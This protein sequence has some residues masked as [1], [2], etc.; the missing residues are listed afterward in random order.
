MRPTQP[1]WNRSSAFS[2][3]PAEPLDHGEHQ[4]QI[5]LDQ[6]PAG[7]LV[8]GLGAGGSSSMV[9]SFF[10]HLQLC[11]VDPGDLHLALHAL[12]PLKPGN[13]MTSSMAG[14]LFSYT[15]SF[16]RFLPVCAKRCWDSPSHCIGSGQGVSAVQCRRSGIS[17]ARRSSTSATDADWD[18]CRT[19]TCRVPEGQVAAII[20]YGP[21]RFFGLF[22][23][24][25]EFYI[26]WECIQRIGDDI[27]LIDKPFQRRDPRPGAEAAASGADKW[28]RGCKPRRA[29]SVMPAERSRLLRI[30]DLR[31]SC[32]RAR[33]RR[34]GRWA[35]TAPR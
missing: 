9:S 21:G 14:G 11:R 32:R 27:I 24:G 25:E 7:L 15:G 20:V 5:P 30:A 4:P 13:F 3:R 17:G 26:P 34:C 18:T 35:G 12:R 29:R 6:L 23:R 10:K 31:A 16:C 2:P 33:R 8:P 19:W 28:P 22:G 1:T